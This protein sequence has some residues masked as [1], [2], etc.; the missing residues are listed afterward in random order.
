MSQIDAYRK[1]GFKGDYQDSCKFEKQE[2]IQKEI[3]RLQDKAESESFDLRKVCRDCAPEV[4]AELLSVGRNW[5]WKG[6]NSDKVAA[7]R[8]ILDRGYG[9][10]KENVDFTGGFVLR[11]ER[12]DGKGV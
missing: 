12:A 5:N 6:G 8:E 10:P 9:K 11:V 2:E 4:I 1:A 7:L 3:G